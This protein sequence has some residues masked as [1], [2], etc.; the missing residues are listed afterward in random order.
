M[1]NLLIGAVKFIA[2]GISGSAAMVSEGIHSFVDCGNG[3][4]VLF[5]IRRSERSADVDH[6]FGYGKEL[7]FW[8]LVVSILVF[9]IGGGMAI[10]HGYEA[11]MKAH[12]GG[13]VMGDPTLNYAILLI[14]MVIEGGSLYIAAKQFNKLRREKNMGALEYIRESKDPSLYTVLLEDTAAEIGLIIALIGTFLGHMLGNPYIDGIASIL[15]GVVLIAVAA[16]IMRESAG[17]LVGEGMS[18]KEVRIIVNIVKEDPSIAECGLVLTNYFGPHD[19]LVSIDAT[20]K[21]SLDLC[22]LMEAI[23]RIEGKVKAR[24]PQT[25]RVFI[26]AKSMACVKVQRTQA[27]ELFQ[28]ELSQHEHDGR[29]LL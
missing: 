23:D 9:S 20:F 28:E 29:R 24:F 5:G 12:S 1:A 25:S 6:P 18:A 26:E 8:T 10:S 4:L 14:A 2:A 7:Y 17:L 15:I 27:E 16:V 22:G 3:L 19:L 21:S 13:Y 11:L